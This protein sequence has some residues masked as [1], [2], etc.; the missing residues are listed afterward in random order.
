MAVP[1]QP[2]DVICIPGEDICAAPMTTNLTVPGIT[3]ALNPTG[4]DEIIEVKHITVTKLK[5]D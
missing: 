2:K 3:S 5:Q 1:H 4:D